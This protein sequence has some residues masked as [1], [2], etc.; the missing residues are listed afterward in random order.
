MSE[1]DLF[2]L[3]TIIMSIW[4]VND[5]FDDSDDELY[6]VKREVRKLEDRVREL[7]DKK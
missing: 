2:I 5:L 4:L 1:N 7:E 3:V 6:D